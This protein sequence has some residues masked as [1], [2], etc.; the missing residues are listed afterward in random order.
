MVKTAGLDNITIETL[1]KR[2]GWG[3]DFITNL[4]KQIYGKSKGNERIYLH[5]AGNRKCPKEF[6]MN[7]TKKSYESLYKII[8]SNF[9]AKKQIK[10]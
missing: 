9:S 3:A 5:N 2:D 1:T 8:T 6:S 10:A 4:I 7:K